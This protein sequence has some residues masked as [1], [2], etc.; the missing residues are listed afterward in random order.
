MDKSNQKKH[1]LLVEDEVL[2]A[3]MEMEQLETYGYSVSHVTNSEAA[4]NAVISPEKSY[5]LILMDINLGSGVDGTECA[6][7]ILQ[8]F[9]IPIVFL[10]SHTE[11][12]VVEKTERITSYGYVVKNSGSTILDTSIKMA[13]KLY[14]EKLKVFEKQIELQEINRQLL[15]ADNIIKEREAL[16]SNKI[17]KIFN[18]EVDLG[19]FNLDEIIDKESVQAVMDDLFKFSGMVM[20]LLDLKGNILI[21]TGWQDICTRFHRLNKDTALRCTESD[22]FLSQ[23]LPAGEIAEYKCKNGLWDVVTPLFIGGK[24]VGNI[25]TGQFFYK[26]DEKDIEYFERQ[27]EQFNLNKHDYL[28]A[29]KP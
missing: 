22:L 27:A 24:H 21:A 9:D 13:F 18:P 19:E 3:M 5:D 1:I 26:E 14:E 4:F 29:L 16:L 11:P 17:D 6:D 12:E 23:K 25:F 28:E 8:H 7:R 10:S 2:I 20:A 15:E